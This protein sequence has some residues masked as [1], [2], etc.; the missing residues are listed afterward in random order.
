MRQA[1]IGDEVTISRYDWYSTDT[2][3][4]DDDRH[5]ATHLRTVGLRGGT[6]YAIRSIR[7]VVPRKRL[8]RGCKHRYVIKA[9][10]LGRVGTDQFTIPEDSRVITLQWDARNTRRV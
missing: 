5:P 1:R 6:M 2:C 8:P 3:L 9:I 7:R 4:P 10:K